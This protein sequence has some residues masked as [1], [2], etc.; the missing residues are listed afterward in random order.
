MLEND[1]KPLSLFCVINHL[2][3]AFISTALSCI[4]TYEML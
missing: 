2:T 4:P 1:G 3:K